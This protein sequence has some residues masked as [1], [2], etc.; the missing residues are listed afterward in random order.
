MNAPFTDLGQTIEDFADIMYVRCPR[1]QQCAQVR[2]LPSIEEIMTADDSGHRS[3]S[4]RKV[5]CLHCSYTRNW[6]RKIQRRGGPYDWYFRLPLWFQT[7]CCGEI[8][9]VFNKEHLSFL[10][11]YVAAKQRIKI[12]ASGGIRNKTLSNRLPT[13]IKK[14]KNRDEIIKGITRLKSL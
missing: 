9:W 6:D 3:F 1:C 13:W 7:P 10:E 14:A 5:S 4:P 2:H 12:T 8:L 11:S